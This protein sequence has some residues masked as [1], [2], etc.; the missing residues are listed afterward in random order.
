MG[1]DW[2]VDIY[3]S[4][5][6]EYKYAEARFWEG[7]LQEEH[8]TLAEQLASDGRSRHTLRSLLALRGEWR[9]EQGQWDSAEDSLREAVRMA[10]AV[11]QTDAGAETRLALARFRLG[12]LAE[13]R[14]EAEQLAEL[15]EPAHRVLAELWLAIGDPE[16]AK[17]HALAAYRWAW[18][19]GEPFVHRYELNKSRA[20]LEQ[21]KAEIPNLPPYDPS[22]DK[23]LRW[24]DA[25]LA[26]IEEL[27]AE[28]AAEAAAKDTEGELSRPTENSSE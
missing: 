7:Y 28:K 18:A 6:A 15:K 3:R 23:K 12:S 2:S 1:R 24:E 9:L 13:P 17:K 25:V 11:G 16:Q 21:L 8:L 27:R 19:E 26:A 5:S 22:K 4:G 20:L 14:Q 10:R